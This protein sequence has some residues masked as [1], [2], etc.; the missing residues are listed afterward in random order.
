MVTD[1]LTP[2]QRR[3]C[4]SRIRNKDTKPEMIVRRILYK[5]GYRYRLHVSHLP[6]KPDLVFSSRNKAI[7]VHG[8]FWHRHNCRFGKVVP[9]TRKAFWTDKLEKNKARD[10]RNR[11]ALRRRGWQVFVV[12]ECQINRTDW[13]T[14]R[15]VSFLDD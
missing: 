7:F 13:I 15:L 12:W 11:A 9:E 1:V 5:L 8:C 10:K 2:T 6:G 14:E 3:Y 4:M